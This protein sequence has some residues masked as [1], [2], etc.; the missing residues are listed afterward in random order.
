[1]NEISDI[2]PASHVAS[3]NKFHWQVR[4]DYE[5]KIALYII[6]RINESLC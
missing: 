6:S 1:M 5:D 4:V 3:V 2:F